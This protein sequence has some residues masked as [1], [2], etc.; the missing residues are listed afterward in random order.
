MKL[1][2]EPNFRRQ[3]V[4]NDKGYIHNMP[5]SGL[6]C[7]YS[8][9][10]YEEEGV[11]ITHPHP[12]MLCIE[13]EHYHEVPLRRAFNLSYSFMAE[14]AGNIPRD[15]APIRYR[16]NMG[17]MSLTDTAPWLYNDEPIY[18][19]WSESYHNEVYVGLGSVKLVYVPD[20]KSGD[21]TAWMFSHVVP[22]PH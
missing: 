10:T 21:S 17:V 7:A 22:L 15:I 13:G 14:D 16:T 18:M 2:I 6:P 1:Y 3:V 4:L 20:T 8:A 5:W 9:D 12:D 11:I 19:D